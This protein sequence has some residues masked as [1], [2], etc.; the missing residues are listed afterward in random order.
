VCAAWSDE[1]QV[2]IARRPATANGWQRHDAVVNFTVQA[3]DPQGDKPPKLLLYY[4]VHTALQQLF[5][6]LLH[7]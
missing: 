6:K 3:M 7:P 5:N 4:D 2:D 1:E